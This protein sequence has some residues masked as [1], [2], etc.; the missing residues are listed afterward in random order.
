[1][2]DNHSVIKISR[3]TAKPFIEKIHYTHS[4]GKVTIAYGLFDNDLLIKNGL[5]D[6]SRLCGVITFGQVSARDLA[7]SIF[8]GGSQE[9]TF[10]F[11][12]MAVLDDCKYP[13]SQFISKSIKLLK[14]EYPK[15]KCLVSFADQTEGHFGYVY[16]A[17]NWLYC[18]TTGKK[19]HFLV[20]GKRVNKRM[21]YDNAKYIGI[22]EKE[23]IE[24]NGWEKVIELPKFR[25]VYPLDKKIILKQ[26]I[27]KYPKIRS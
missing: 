3:N 16:Q 25:Y 24:K 26:K 6:M 18:G 15:I 19:Y 13:R 21:A 20:N 22:S 17:S 9:N 7:Q 1:M 8:E 27:L 4:I 2:S 23:Y 12:R 10:E 14:S 5:F 11:L